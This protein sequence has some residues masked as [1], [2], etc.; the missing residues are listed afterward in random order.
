MGKSLG[1]SVLTG[2]SQRGCQPDVGRSGAAAKCNGTWLGPHD[3]A[4]PSAVDEEADGLDFAETKCLPASIPVP[5]AKFKGLLLQNY[6]TPRSFDVFKATRGFDH[7]KQ[8]R[9]AALQDAEI[10]EQDPEL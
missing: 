9:A 7:G 2:L 5:N 4:S 10:L 3:I 1:V 8:G 6:V